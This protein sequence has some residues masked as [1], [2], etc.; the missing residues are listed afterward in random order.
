MGSCEPHKHTNQQGTRGRVCTLVSIPFL[1]PARLIREPSVS[2]RPGRGGRLILGD[3]PGSWHELGVSPCRYDVAVVCD[4]EF[5]ALLFLAV[6]LL[7]PSSGRH[8]SLFLFR[9]GSC[10]V[11]RRSLQ[12]VL[13]PVR[14]VGRQRAFRRGRGVLSQLA[15]SGHGPSRTWPLQLHSASTRGSTSNTEQYRDPRLRPRGA[16][17][18]TRQ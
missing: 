10:S 5:G 1:S 2:G 3:P 12:G 7:S 18:T 14:R 15:A 8:L 11:S 4:S 6:N 13:C 17:F 16:N 9:G